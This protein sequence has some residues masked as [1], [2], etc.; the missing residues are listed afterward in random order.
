MATISKSWAAQQQ[1]LG[2]SADSWT[3]MATGT[4]LNYSSEVDLETDGY[5]GAHVIV[6][7]DGPAAPTD[8]VDVSIFAAIDS[9]NYDDY[10]L[11]SQRI[12]KSSVAKQI[13]IIVKDVAQFKVGVQHSGGTDSYTARVYCQ[14]WRWQSA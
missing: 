4:A 7:V 10:A 6:E 13:S 1:I 11:F 14:R 5:E 3:T 8:Y 2:G 12:E 9:T